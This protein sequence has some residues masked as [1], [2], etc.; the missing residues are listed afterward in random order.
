MHACQHYFAKRTRQP[1]H[2][3][4]H[5]TTTANSGTQRESADDRSRLKAY[6]TEMGLILVTIRDIFGIHVG[7]KELGTGI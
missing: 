3:V 5:K 1:G 6:Q 2:L 7:R 4:E